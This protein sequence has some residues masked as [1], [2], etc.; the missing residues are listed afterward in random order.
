MARTMMAAAVT[1]AYGARMLSPIVWT[2]R[3][4]AGIALAGS[5]TLTPARAADQPTFES[6][7]Q[8]VNAK[9]NIRVIDEP[10]DVRIEVPD[11]QSIYFFTKP[12][13][14][15]HPAV[16]KRSVVQRGSGTAIETEGHCFGGPDAQAAFARHLAQIKAKDEEIA[17]QAQ[18]KN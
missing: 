12:G 4:L 6:V 14:P 1:S 11:E 18:K 3:A 7:W 8:A 13:Q 9:P 16:L 2:L 17:S 10:H 15:E 5:L